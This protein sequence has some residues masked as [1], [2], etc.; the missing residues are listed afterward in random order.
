M[1]VQQVADVE[2]MLNGIHPRLE[3][4]MMETAK[5]TARTI[6]RRMAGSAF[7]EE[8]PLQ[9]SPQRRVP[10]GKHPSRR[11]S[12]IGRERGCPA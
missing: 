10:P 9:G 8:V 7:P 11:S 2:E 5:H 1:L 6:S 4:G 3:D 12:Q